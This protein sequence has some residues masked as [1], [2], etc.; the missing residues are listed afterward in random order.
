M[1]SSEDLFRAIEAGDVGSVRALLDEDP[2]VAGARDADGVSAALRA[3][4]HREPEIEAAIR[5]SGPPPDVFEAAA[6]GDETRL[7]ELLDEDPGRAGGVSGDG[8]T[9]LHFAA[10][11]GGV[12]VTR[13]LL[14]RGAEVDVHGR[15]WMTGTP[16]HSAASNRNADVVEVLLEAGADPNA[17]QA[18]G[19]TPLHGAA[20]NG[21]AR[22]AGLLLEA[23]ADPSARNDEGRSVSELADEAGDA[24][25]VR[26]VRSA[27]GADG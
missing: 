9:A 18:G 5:A 12:G 1:A 19:W 26:L 24:A 17:R 16:L 23:G 27:L 6:F 15:G 20:H 11:W 14:E 13:L 25:T 10:F 3:R 2:A 8:F 22:T 21:D 7:A 4:Y